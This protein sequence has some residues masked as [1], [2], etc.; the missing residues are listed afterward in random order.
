MSITNLENVIKRNVGDK[1]YFIGTLPSN[2]AK[3]ATFVPVVEDSET[4]LDQRLE[5]GYQRPGKK[6]RMN[7][8]KNYSC[9]YDLWDKDNTTI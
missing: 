2:L 6:S 4:Y 8:F 5:N 1:S 9:L 7:Q 3:A